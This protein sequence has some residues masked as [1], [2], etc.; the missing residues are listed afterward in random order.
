MGVACKRHGRHSIENLDANAAGSL[1]TA[2][3]SAE[4]HVVILL[5]REVRTTVATYE[6]VTLATDTSA[7]HV[8]L[9]ASQ[10]CNDLVAIFW[11]LDDYNKNLFP[12]MLDVLRTPAYRLTHE[13]RD[14]SMEI[15]VIDGGNPTHISGLGTDD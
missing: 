7:A 14:A 3:E 1:Y 15:R 6:Y 2:C 10:H 11:R 5:L 8:G 9:V 12:F 4:E 13:S